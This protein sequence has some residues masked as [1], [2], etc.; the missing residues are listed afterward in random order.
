MF[1]T[2]DYDVFSDYV[3]ALLRDIDLRK[4]ISANAVTLARKFDHKHAAEKLDKVLREGK[5]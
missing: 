5:G 3:I 2:D 1:V 4:N